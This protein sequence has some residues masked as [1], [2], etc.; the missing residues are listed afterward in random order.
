VTTANDFGLMG[1]APSH[2]ELLDWLA[3]WFRDEAKG[4][5]KELHRLLV[6]SETYRQASGM[7]N[8][9]FG[10]R[11]EPTN[12]TGRGIPHS[13]F[14][15]PQSE[16]PDN[17]LLARMNRTRLD[18]ECLRDAMLQAS[19]R[20]DL[21]MGGPGDYQF[22][23]QPGIHVTPRVDYT[24]F[25]VD[26]AAGRRR[27]VY[28]FLFRTLPDPFMDAL[29]CPAGDQLTAARNNSVTVQQALALWNNAFAV[30]QTEHLATR[31]AAEAN[32][33]EAQLQRAFELTLGRTATADEL[34]DFTTHARQHGLANCCRLL[35]NSNEFVFI[36]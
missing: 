3:V 24:K 26:S 34:A 10:I 27:S 23:L 13:A 20:L 29:D 28:R 18:A 4:S 7:R 2:P 16:D 5:F 15:T 1:G 25:D 9:E 6:T 32:S 30:R 21:R 19:G 35:F 8:S 22:D 36:N 33:V 11:N 17:R 14:R 31:L 12:T